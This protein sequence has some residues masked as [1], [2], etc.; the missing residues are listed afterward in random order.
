M[1]LQAAPAYSSVV[2]MFALHDMAIN[3]MSPRHVKTHAMPS[4]ITP[5]SLNL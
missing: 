4:C 2:L 5:I 3:A 1:L